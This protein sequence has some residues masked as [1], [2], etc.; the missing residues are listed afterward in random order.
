MGSIRKVPLENCM[1]ELIGKIFDRKYRV[2]RLIGEGG[3]GSVY[4]AEHTVIQRKVAVKVMHNEFSKMPEVVER[5][6]R[7]AQ[8]SSAIGHPN[9]I[10]VFDV[11]IEEDGAVF[12]VMELLTGEPLLERLRRGELLSPETAVAIILQVLSALVVAHNKGIIHRDLKPDNVFLSVDA[13]GRHEVK[14]LDFGIAKVQGALDG[15]QGLT[16]TGTVLGTPN[17]MSPEQ[18]RG[19]DVDARIDIWAAGVM[20]YQMLS[21]RL[22]YQGES[23]NEVL[24]SILLDDP[25]RLS[26]LVSSVP[27]DLATVV[28]RAM[29]KDRDDRYDSV[30]EM[31]QDLI[32]FNDEAA[33]E[34][35]SDTAALALKQSMAPPPPV[36]EQD[37]IL[38]T[39]EAISSA[40]RSRGGVLT[41]RQQELQRALRGISTPGFPQI[42]GSGGPYVT[43][44]PTGVVG[45]P[46]SVFPPE[47][48]DRAGGTPYPPQKR[49][50]RLLGFL[51]VLALLIG[52]V[53]GVVYYKKKKDQTFI[54]SGHALYGQVAALWRGTVE[55]LPPAPALSDFTAALS[56]DEKGATD[57]AAADA[58]SEPEAAQDGELSNTE[59]PIP[60]EVTIKVKGLPKRAQL[61]LDGK[62]VDSPIKLPGGQKP[63]MLK[64][65]S[66]HYKT[67]SEEIVPDRDQIVEFTLEKKGR[68]KR[69]PRKKTAKSK[70]HKK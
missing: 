70:K 54:E 36:S 61:T 25:P 19:R 15:D 31:I 52:L 39:H 32:P 8:A 56:E 45:P 10:E 2:T 51:L 63:L 30:A 35:M 64:M 69:A 57:T 7:E 28:E 22:P 58:P 68:A 50:S 23:Y 27:R 4:E 5:F 16:K 24:S 33:Q 29:E 40:M 18:A 55:E 20:L 48:V 6:F 26:D 62:K 37:T 66:K 53:V 65:T 3:M 13:R 21:G 47:N 1:T 17:Y 49:R 41:P 67:I 14:L 34:L 42:S 11:G 59:A 9:I 44:S 43:P 60:A 12:I 38:S 46:A